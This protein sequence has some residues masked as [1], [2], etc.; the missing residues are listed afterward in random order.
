MPYRIDVLDPPDDALDC[1]VRL[2]ALDLEDIAG[3]L[4]AI[5][6]DSVGVASVMAALGDVRVTASP[7]IG[8]DD[9]SVWLLRARATRVR[10]WLIVPAHLPAPADALR[11][12]DG[13]AFG[14]GLHPTTVLSLE[15]LDDVLT[16]T[17]PS[18]VLDV[19]TG[20]GV[21]ALAALM[22]GVQDAV[23]LDIDLAA[24][25][26]AGENARTNN[27][28]ERLDLVHGGPEAVRGQWPLVLANVV[29]APLM[30]MAPTLVQR[31]AHGGYL[32]LSGIPDTVAPEVERVYQR[33]GMQRHRV[34]TRLG[35]SLV[36]LR[37]SW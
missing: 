19:G 14:T 6:P 2:G 33:L 1:L 11:L 34:E 25:G 9:G 27:L 16:D 13:T 3:G 5:M 36:G 28:G 30:E 4:A 37:P 22:H 12:H 20:S 29:A 10:R 21:L 32:V 26:V 24:L 8:R 17:V 7:A 23:G 35:W 15:V 31:V 18:R